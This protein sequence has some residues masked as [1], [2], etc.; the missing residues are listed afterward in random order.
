MRE[1]IIVSVVSIITTV[2][3]FATLLTVGLLMGY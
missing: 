1:F 3:V 2:I